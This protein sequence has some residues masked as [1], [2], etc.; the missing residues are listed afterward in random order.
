MSL[1]MYSMW[2]G[3]KAR[4]YDPAHVS[5]KYYGARGIK[6]CERWLRSFKAFAEDM[7]ERPSMDHTL[8]RIDNNGNYEPGNC[9]FATPIEQARNR[10]STR[11]VQYKGAELPLIDLA[12]SFG[13]GIHTLN[14][15]IKS[16]LSA[17]ISARAPVRSKCK[18][19]TDCWWYVE[20]VDDDLSDCADYQQALEAYQESTGATA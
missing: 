2:Y 14:S 13:V 9:K 1:P 18:L 12:E 11:R 7:G 15:R 5:Y 16:G 4:C 6:V 20:P 19:A 10:R 8:E 17:E 3:M